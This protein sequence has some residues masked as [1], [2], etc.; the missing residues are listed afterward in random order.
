MHR[1]RSSLSSS[2]LLIAAMLGCEA[3]AIAQQ[4]VTPTPEELHMTS[5]PE[6]PDA[7]AVIL[8]HDEL[9]DDDNHMRSSYSR[10]KILTEAGKEL[11]DVHLE[12][13]RRADGLGYG[14]SEI[15]G[16][17]IQPDGTIVPFSGKPFDKVIHKDR[18]DQYTIKVFSMPAVQVGSIIE[19]RY[20]VRWEDHIFYHPY[21]EIQTDLYLRRGHYL[22][23]PTDREL[24]STSRGGHESL[25]SSL[26]WNP[27]LP[28]GVEVAK[29]RLPTGRALLELNVKDVPPFGRE[30]YMPPIQSS[31]YHVDFYYS[32]YKSPQEFWSTEGKYWSSDVNK[33]IGN[34]SF[35][36]DAATE[37]IGGAATDEDKLRKLYALTGR[38]ENTDFTRRRSS[39]EEKTE[40]LKETKSAEDV[41]RRK[42][43]SSDQIAMTFVALSRSLG[44]NASVMASGD[45]SQ[46]VVNAN[47]LEFGQLTDDLAI[48][49]YGGADHFFD[50]GSPYT[51][52]G[53]LQ[54]T[55]SSS[56]GVRQNGK[57]TA[58]AQ[59]PS[60]SYKY[61]RSARVGDL[62][63][64]EDGRLS[65]TVTFTLQGSY[66]QSLRQAALR[67]DEAELRED[68]KHQLGNLLPGVGEIEVKSVDGLKDGEIPLKV[69]Y[70]VAGQ[71]GTTAGSRMVLPSDI[72]VEH[73]RP[74]FPHDKREQ[75]VYFPYPNMMQ[76]AVRI[77][78]PA[79]FT[80]ESAPAA[81]HLQY[82][83]MAVYDQKS[84]EAANSITVW[85]DLFIGEFLF[86]LDEYP[87]LRSFYSSF[88]R[89]DHGSVVLKRTSH[90]NAANDTSHGK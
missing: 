79:G 74:V 56:G 14:I 49:N 63:L 72:F 86:P 20:K 23:K 88:E 5:V 22:W 21:W 78:Y 41:L 61:S 32:P 71:M 10:V 67:S 15:A 57:E 81:E 36:H 75:A 16:R 1:L 4:W 37:V 53:H 24:L 44:M 45:R 39:A 51:P 25:T 76:D 70:S 33:F 26:T 17:T 18:T 27:V 3:A 58:F 73:S 77:T 50:P 8:Y 62:K 7:R 28:P 12:F 64:E 2:F 52:F 68:L 87:Q 85:R 46:R 31:R 69:V 29:T 83:N 30:E 13:D 47:W 34:S 54:W 80:V 90:E 89:K 40:G 19:Y 35:V 82:K 6:V 60:E 84:K 59:T 38:L 48:V 65:G 66:A 55:H 9:A 42:R 11:G 43:G